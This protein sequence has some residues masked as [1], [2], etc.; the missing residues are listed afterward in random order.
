[1]SGHKLRSALSS[2]T[3]CPLDLTTSG[4]ASNKPDFV[5][6]GVMWDL[7][8]V[9]FQPVWYSVRHVLRQDAAGNHLL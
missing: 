7:K 5:S 4:W 9:R 3:C 6:G 2:L 8:F 1:M